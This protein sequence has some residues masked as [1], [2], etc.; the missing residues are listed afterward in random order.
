M[1]T[2]ALSSRTTIDLVNH[3]ATYS[4]LFVLAINVFFGF[5]YWKKLNTPFRRLFY[6]LVWN[7]MIEILAFAFMKYGYNNLPLLH[8][9]TLGEFI[10]FSYFYKSLINK[11]IRFQ[12][13]FLYFLISG[14]FFIIV[15]SIFF[16][17]IFGFNSFAKTF[18]QI[19][20]IGFA[21]L[22]FYNLIENQLYS[23]A[24]SKGLRLVNSAV[25]IYYSG[26]LFVF[27]YGKF[28]FANTDIFTFFWAFNSVLYLL[29]QLFILI[30]LWK[31]SYRKRTL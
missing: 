9:Y 27:M 15:N 25:L 21:V 16:Q 6:F 19:T 17:S 28:S 3:Y 10:L 13:L 5:A 1:Y 18:V 14:S 26:S 24:A 12:K 2:I 8:I 23:T 11:P 22:Y 31:I 4:A 29:F 20:I 7:S 30:A